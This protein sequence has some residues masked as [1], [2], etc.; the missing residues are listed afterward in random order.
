MQFGTASVCYNWDEWSNARACSNLTALYNL[1][2]LT[3]LIFWAIE[4]S[5]KL[6]L[7]S[8]CCV[9]CTECYEVHQYCEQIHVKVWFIRSTMYTNSFKS[10][11]TDQLDRL[12]IA[13]QTSI[14]RWYIIGHR[15]FFPFDITT[16]HFSLV[17]IFL[18]T[19]F[20]SFIWAIRPIYTK[21]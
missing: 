8:L 16:I 12:Q 1:H 20:C 19:H 3:E 9:P 17:W 7:L 13:M 2:P 10:V 21:F 5:N 14:K 18:I 15:V 6:I 11:K 4:M